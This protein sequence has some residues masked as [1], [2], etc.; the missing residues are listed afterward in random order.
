[1]LYDLKL[2]IP[3]LKIQGIDI[4]KYAI[5]NSKEDVR[6]Y[7]SVANATNLPFPIIHLMW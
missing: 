1:M 7:L 6:K 2:K 4:S 5:E 3:G